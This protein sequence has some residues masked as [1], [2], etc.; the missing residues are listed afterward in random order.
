MADFKVKIIKYDGTEDDE[1]TYWGSVFIMPNHIQT[2]E[3]KDFDATHGTVSTTFSFPQD[4]IR[5]KTIRS[6]RLWIR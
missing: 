1:H 3:L 2:K 5:R 4:V 6:L